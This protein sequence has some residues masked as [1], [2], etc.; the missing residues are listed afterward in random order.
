MA[1]VR[2]RGA[3]S[4][5][6]HRRR[7]LSSSGQRNFNRGD[8][9]DHIAQPHGIGEP[10]HRLFRIAPA[11]S[12]TGL[13]PHG[14]QPGEPASRDSGLEQPT[15]SRSVGWE[16]AMR[17]PAEQGAAG[18]DREAGSWHPPNNP[19]GGVAPDHP[20][21]CSGRYRFTAQLT[22]LAGL[23]PTTY[24]LGNRRS[25]QLS[26]SPRG[27]ITLANQL[28][29]RGM[30]KSES[31]RGGCGRIPSCRIGWRKVRPSMAGLAGN[32]QCG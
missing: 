5:L 29:P 4:S 32:A 27:L 16:S 30:M 28:C 17:S 1:P 8:D 25:I 9:T 19:S 11:F 6:P 26:Y 10:A 21:K 22:G 12:I 13:I 15:R 24:G 20:T 18:G 3:A 31:R 23:E 14:L 2:Q 7:R